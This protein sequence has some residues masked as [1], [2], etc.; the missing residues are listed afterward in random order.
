[1]PILTNADILTGSQPLD[2]A[3]VQGK[4]SILSGII[5]Q[6]AS[7]VVI[8]IAGEE[9]GVVINPDLYEAQAAFQEGGQVSLLKKTW[10]TLFKPDAAPALHEQRREYFP[11]DSQTD[12]LAQRRIFGMGSFVFLSLDDGLYAAMVQRQAPKNDKTG[13]VAIGKYSRAAGAA[14]GDLIDRQT[15]ELG[16]ELFAL[17]DRGTHFDSLVFEPQPNNCTAGTIEKIF[18]HKKQRIHEILADPKL[19]ND[20]AVQAYHHGKEVITRTQP[21]HLLDVAELVKRIT[22]N[23]PGNLTRSFNGYVVDDALNG[24]FNIDQVGIVSLPGVTAAQI[25][26]LDDEMK[27]LRRPWHLIKTDELVAMLEQRRAEFSPAPAQ[28]IRNMAMFLRE[29]NA[30]AVPA[31]RGQSEIS[32]LPR[33]G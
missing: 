30:P 23:M 9:P 31:Q 29:I 16:E 4:T 20:P 21:Y 5:E 7:D 28:V 14:D 19:Q 2:G 10:H 3:C 26:L 22:V 18:M 1:M 17:V 12:F 27:D 15:W 24:D 8:T 32:T 13:A 25:T 33:L 6:Q 11:E